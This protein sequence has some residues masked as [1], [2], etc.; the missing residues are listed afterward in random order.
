MRS[1]VKKCLVFW[2]AIFSFI[3]NANEINIVAKIEEDIITNI[4]IQ[5]RIDLYK[6]MGM[7]SQK[8][9]DL[10]TRNEVLDVM[11]EEKILELMLQQSGNSISR[12]Q[13]ELIALDTPYYND[14]DTSLQ[15]SYVELIKSDIFKQKIYQSLQGT[16]TVN[17]EEILEKS[18]NNGLTEEE[19]KN[20]LI[21]QKL[22][23]KLQQ[24][25]SGY[26]SNLF[27]EKTS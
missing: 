17:N 18:K 6:Q 10:E 13:V 4:D 20:A 12:S 22:N 5:N 23:L 16:V 2:C 15:D 14:I 25:I 24:L 26:K 8:N 27:I 21:M 9:I 19:A 11:I 7:L 1:I 3:A